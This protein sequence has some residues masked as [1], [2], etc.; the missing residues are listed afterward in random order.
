VTC[1]ELKE[2]AG[3]YALGALDADERAAVEQHLTETGHDGCREAL[4]EAAR[5]ADALA[6]ALP[7]EAPAPATWAAIQREI[8]VGARRPSGRPRR[9][10]ARA[11]PWALLAAAALWLFWLNDRRDA[12][13]RARAQVIARAQDLTRELDDARLQAQTA[14]G[15]RAE[16]EREL[17]Q[18]SVQ[19]ELRT[20]AVAMLEHPGTRVVGF[21][22]QGKAS[23]GATAIVNL[24]EG[25]AMVVAHG[26]AP[27]PGKDYELWIL[28]GDQKIAAGLLRGTGA[29]QVIAA[30]DP[31][32]LAGGVD[33]L[34][35]TLEP[36]GG[37]TQPRGELVLVA[38]LS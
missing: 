34:A 25:R 6:T 27:P 19:L 32:L 3:A 7:P 21:A 29:G 4:A 8:G 9:F 14:A 28:R 23:A 17:A 13:Q 22:R 26:V 15:A 12:E 36:Q 31:A 2:L 33:G 11:L 16:C 24:R 37:G 35:V 5:V 10:V 18:V 1:A 20:Q 30:I 38:S